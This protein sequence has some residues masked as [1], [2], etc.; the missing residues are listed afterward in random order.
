MM[1]FK[2]NIFFILA[3]LVFANVSKAQWYKPEKVNKKAI[4]V[5]EA[6]YDLAV[7]GNYEKSLNKLDEALA[8]EPKYV[9]AYLSRA[10][11]Y[12]DLK[13]YTASV[14]D[15]SKAFSLDSI[16]SSTYLLPYSISLAGIGNFELALEKVTAFLNTEKLN[17]QSIKS[18]NYR[19]RTYEFALD[20]KKKHP[21]GDYHFDPVNLGD[22]I[23]TNYLEYYPSL[24]IDGKKMIFTRRVNNDEDFYESENINGVWSKATPAKGKI[25]TTL[26][27]GA[28]SISQ[29]GQWLIFTGCN[30]PEGQGSC[31][32]YISFKTK[33]G[34]WTEAENIGP[35]VNTDLWESAPSLS[36][37]K[38]DL[39]FSSN[40]F[41]GYGG[42][43]IWVTHRN[44]SGKWTVPE[45]LGPTINTSGDETC[46][47]IHPDNQTL[48]FNSN[49][50]PGYGMADLFLT[51]KGVDNKWTTPL[52]LGYPI[53]TIDDEGSLIVASDGYTSYYASD[54]K[55]KNSGLDI[56]SFI[57]P[58]ELS[59]KKTLWINGNVFDAKSKL[60]LPSMATLTCLGNA[61][62]STQIQTDEDG[63]FLITL[64]I[65]Y[66][67]SLNINRKGYLFYSDHFSLPENTTDSFF[68]LNVPLQP[69][70]AG[71]SIVLKNIFFGNNETKLQPESEAELNKIVSLLNENP[72]MKVQ[73]SGHTDNVGKKEANQLLS[74][75]RA[76]SVVNYLVGKGITINR[77]LPKGFGDTKP[78]ASND[79]DEGK[80][81]NRRTEIN[82]VSN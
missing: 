39:Y 24:T 10:G 49:G 4:K 68:K 12:G 26:N 59:A 25:N 58:K 37:D 20:Y 61:N 33:S 8:I 40:R 3:F 13:N 32:L 64:P 79:T 82:V 69:I 62:F 44:A 30:Y 34:S 67:Y 22:G 38:K 18:G 21:T 6:A 65:G 2:L 48:Y 28:Q 7:E 14:N 17:S 77:L 74:L 80:S 76:K 60:G 63:N 52:N 71:A 16:F 35:I 55:N 36:P 73:I 66:E 43:D 31:D 19:K 5:Y 53:N 50:L 41:N 42:K 51:R 15:F 78:V 47:F 54:R 11:I 1:N 29:D 45:N 81:L 23:N 57:L 27:E 46:P 75:N 9:E 56:Y 72:N 70:E